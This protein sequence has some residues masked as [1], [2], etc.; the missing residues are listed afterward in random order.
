[1]AQVMGVVHQRDGIEPQSI[2]GA[3]MSVIAV[4]GTAPDADDT[5]FPLDTPILLY[6]NDAA[7]RTA[8]GATGT[9]PDAIIGISAQLITAA[10]KVVIV[11]VDDDAS[12]LTQIGL[13]I[14]SEASRT[15]MWALLDAPED[16]GVTPRLIIVPGYTS[17]TYLGI[18]GHGAITGGTGGTNGTFALAFTGGTGSGAAGTFTVAGGAL[19]AI[20]ITNPGAYTVAPT[21]SFA[22]STGLTGA[23]ASVTSATLG[24]QICASIPT[25]LARLKAKFLPEGPTDSHA[26]WLTWK[27]LLPED[28]NIIHPLAQDAMVLSGESIVTKPL[29]PYII[30]L[31]ARRDSEFDGIPGHSV[32]NQNINGLVGIS[33]KIDLDITS[34]SSL[35]MTYIEENAGIVIRGETGVDGSLTDGGF[36]FWGTDTLAADTQWLFANV[37][38]L[39]DY[40]EINQ[41]KALRTYLGRFNL[42]IQTVQAV[43][44]TMESELSK[45]RANGDLLDYRIDFVEDLNTP[46]DL[47]LGFLTIAFR[48]EEPP[49]LRKITVRSRRY[50]D[51]LT[52]LVQNIS[53][54][55]G[56]AVA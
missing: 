54:Q 45:M 42:T 27:E 39:R 21:F 51:A 52:E 36:I 41:I 47:R 7:A 4:I 30:A 22:T 46:E 12:A 26:N 50:R 2:L 20:N 9:I 31:Y 44:N 35:G 24:N 29:S 19:T 48:A 10:A 56:S 49:P 3:D 17:Q 53:I 13:L 11:R 34:D 16:L 28:M 33:P 14:G 38:R 8:L 23:S 32:A 6:T 43:V 15:G 37:V 55:L 25:I 18:T 1:M 5:A 40:I